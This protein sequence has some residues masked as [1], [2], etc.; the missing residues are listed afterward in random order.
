MSDALTVGITKK[1]QYA[2]KQTENRNRI[3]VQIANEQSLKQHPH[4]L[5]KIAF[6]EMKYFRFEAE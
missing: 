5:N 4:F 2:V 6:L 3:S 1:N